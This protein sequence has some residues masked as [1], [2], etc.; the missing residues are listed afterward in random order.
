MRPS[1]SV[2]PNAASISTS[3]IR[4]RHSQKRARTADLPS[5]P[6]S[7]QTPE[8]SS[9]RQRLSAEDK[10]EG[11]EDQ[12]SALRPPQFWDNLSRVP[13][14]KAALRELDRRYDREN[15]EENYGHFIEGF[16]QASTPELLRFAR[17]G[18]PDLSDLRGIDKP[19]MPRSQ[20]KPR[21][22]VKKPPLSSR[23]RSGSRG[24]RG[25][26]G[27][28]G[29]PGSR[30][31]SDTKT[32]KTKSSNS[33]YDLAFKQHLIDFKI[34]PINHILPNNEYP[35]PPDNL[36]DLINEV[37]GNGRASLEPEAFGAQQHERFSRAYILGVSE[38][39]QSRTLDMVEGE[40]L[41]ISAA[42][43]KRGPVKLTNLQPLTPAH[44]VPGNP[45]R[46]YGARPET[47]ERSIRDYLGTLVLPTAAQDILC[48]NF[49]VHI[50]GPDG[51]PR[52]AE[53]QAVYDGALAARGI[54]ALWDFGREGD[55]QDEEHEKKAAIAR[56]L[57]CTFADG[58]LRIFAVAR[59][60]RGPAEMNRLHEQARSPPEDVEYVTAR[61]G[62]W[63]MAEDLDG[64]RRGALAFRNGL[65]WARRQRDEAITRANKRAHMTP[66]IA[67]VS[68]DDGDH[69]DEGDDGDNDSSQGQTLP[70]SPD[71]IM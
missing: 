15:Y 37:C 34:F 29:S 13:L 32:L 6:Q 14:V 61:L 16:A 54:Q 46:A 28:R 8:K 52:V 49:I 51:T 1:L 25:R 44:F 64:F 53:I 18:G 67:L 33:P 39:A 10:E 26:R 38:E 47:L 22:G 7:N 9:K 68:G 60:Q 17:H 31:G 55:Q 5:P 66:V 57:T 21:G 70:S 43:V 62:S 20:A 59:R 23:S 27:S 40:S 35:M 42:H 69:G 65:E 63:L 71:P 2:V 41:T 12:A 36:Q 24:G 11:T 50:K 30:D 45:D 58:I 48:P 56:T 4:T 3:T 19:E